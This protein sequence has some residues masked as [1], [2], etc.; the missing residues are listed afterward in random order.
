MA[1]CKSSSCSLSKLSRSGSSTS[2]SSI[3]NTLAFL[4]ASTRSRTRKDLVPSTKVS[5]TRRRIHGPI[6]WY[7]SSG[8]PAVRFQWTIK[9]IS[10][11]TTIELRIIRKHPN[12]RH[13]FHFGL[14]DRRPQFHRH[15]TFTINADSSRPHSNPTANAKR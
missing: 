10:H 11:E 15:R 6:S 3:P 12:Y 2:H 5:P 4:I 9:E 8:R 7:R 1:G 14:A 13:C